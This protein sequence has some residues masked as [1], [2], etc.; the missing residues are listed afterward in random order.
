MAYYVSNYS[1]LRI[2]KLE[3]SVTT[4]EKLL[5]TLEV[6][7]P[8]PFAEGEQDFLNMFF[9]DIYKPIPLIYNLDCSNHVMAASRQCGARQS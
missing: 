6:T 5:V 1:K 9:K 7:P 4:Y 3:P 8:T 2:W